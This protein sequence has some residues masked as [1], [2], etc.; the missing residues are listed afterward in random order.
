MFFEI[1]YFIYITTQ[2]EV[3]ISSIRLICEFMLISNNC[4]LHHLTSSIL[5]PF[6]AIFRRK[7]ASDLLILPI[8][9][10][11][12]YYFKKVCPVLMLNAA[13]ASAS[14]AI[15]CMWLILLESLIIIERNYTIKI[16][17]TENMIIFSLK[18]VFLSITHLS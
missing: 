11:K 10:I 14:N 16:S 17:I 1:H 7:F 9:F 8:I 13:F 12:R 18:I 3:A 6:E 4:F 2:F 5:W 15:S